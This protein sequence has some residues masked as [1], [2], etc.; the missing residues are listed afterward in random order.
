MKSLRGF[1]LIEV[2]VA[3]V[4]LALI[5]AMAFR[6]LDSVLAAKSHVAGESRKWRD[7]SLFFSRLEEDLSR[8]AHRPALDAAGVV[9]SEFSAKE[10][11]AGP[12][13]ANLFF[14]RMGYDGESPERV[15]Y[16]FSQ[17]KVEELV[18]AHLDQAP[19]SKPAVY[20][21]LNHVKEFKLQ[22]LAVNNGWFPYWPLPGQL[23]PK[24]VEASLTL[25]S[26]EKIVRIFSLL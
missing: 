24:A 14:T 9:Q 3:L 4:L 23:R 25:E 15:A 10:S 8:C 16:R 22:Y 6:G 19:G 1:T 20:P 5:A 12:L 7:I 11:L 2:L 18:W 21:L 13:D 26:G 17:G